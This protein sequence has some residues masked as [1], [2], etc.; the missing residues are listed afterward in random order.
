MTSGS[1]PR[2]AS[3]LGLEDKWTKATPRDVTTQLD[4]VGLEGYPWSKG[5]LVLDLEACMKYTEARGEM[6]LI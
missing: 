3:S 1:I 5:T 4:R 6:V 2:L